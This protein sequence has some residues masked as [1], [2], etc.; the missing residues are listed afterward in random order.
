MPAPFAAVRPG[1]GAVAHADAV[2]GY[3]DEY[4]VAG[5]LAAQGDGSAMDARLEAVLDAVFDKRL[6][7]NAGHEDVERPRIDFFFDMQLVGAEADHL[8]VE[9]VV[10]EAE[11]V[12]EGN[13]G[14][15]I[16]EQRAQNVG[17]LHGHLASQSRA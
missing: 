7:E 15:V 3:L 12:A 4:A 5:K 9:V 2:V 6:Q 13:V 14:V 11:F 8:D 17:E 1:A 10:G 16:L